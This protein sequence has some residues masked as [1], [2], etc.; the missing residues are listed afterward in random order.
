MIQWVYERTQDASTVT[1]VCVVTDDERISDAVKGFG[2]KVLMTR[3]EHC[4]GTDRIAE[5]AS[6]TDAGIIVNVQGDEP[7]IEPDM[8]DQ[9]V[10][11]MLLDPD[12]EMSTLAVRID[13]D[14]EYLDPHAVKVTFDEAGDA[15]YF[16][17]SP[18]PFGWTKDAAA[19]SFK[20]IGLYVYRRDVIMRFS[21][22]SR[23]LLE[24]TEK[25]EQLRAVENGIKI[26]VVETEFNPASVDTPE[27]LERVRKMVRS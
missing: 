7:F 3:G 2:G 24:R 12:I 14:E 11:P 6:A 15:L 26:R 18:I 5:A 21:V 13:D 8:I 20:H 9:A 22:L 1:D 23:S 19:S 25:L 10:R 17:R 16:S 4:C 27:D